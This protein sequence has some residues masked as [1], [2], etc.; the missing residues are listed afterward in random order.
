MAP[1]T[2]NTQRNNHEGNVPT[3]RRI[4]SANNNSNKG[5]TKQ[6]HEA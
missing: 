4:P 5:L 6:R 2:P 1:E 3:T